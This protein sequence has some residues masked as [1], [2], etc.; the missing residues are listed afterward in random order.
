MELNDCS[1]CVIHGQHIDVRCPGHTIHFMGI[2]YEIFMERLIELDGIQQLED[3][4]PHESWSPYLL[5]DVKADHPR[6]SSQSSTRL[7][8]GQR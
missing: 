6:T 4:K 2:G 1:T 7:S 5:Q 8:K 3:W